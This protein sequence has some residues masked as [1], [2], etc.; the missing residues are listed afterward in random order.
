MRVWDTLILALSLSDLSPQLFQLGVEGDAAN[1]RCCQF[2]ILGSKFLFQALQLRQR[3]R[4]YGRGFRQ[5]FWPEHE[6]RCGAAPSAIGSCQPICKM[7]QLPD[8]SYSILHH[9]ALMRMN[10]AI[11]E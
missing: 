3:L 11:T 7:K 5:G 8:R 2:V 1:G 6:A 4:R 9:D 10:G